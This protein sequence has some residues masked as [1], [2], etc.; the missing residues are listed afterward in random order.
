M[1][2]RA[3][4][5]FC[6]LAG[7]AFGTAA[8]GQTPA[9]TP[10]QPIDGAIRV[11]WL[12]TENLDPGGLAENVALGAI[13]TAANSP[14]EYG[15]HWSGFAKRTGMVTANYG[16]KSTM[17]GGL[18]AIWGE[19]PRYDRAGAGQPFGKRVGHVIAMTFLARTRSGGTM[20]AYARFVAIPGS[21]FLFNTWM[22]DSQATTNQA[23]IRAGLGFLSRMGENA[24]K[25]FILRK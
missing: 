1:S 20:P 4:G 22:P 13:G 18:S 14:K 2:I 24:Y 6:L 15:T 23:L 5:R 8:F 17:E 21:S 7:I 11:H 3:L 12:V 16:V 9:I 19:D 10:M 25:E